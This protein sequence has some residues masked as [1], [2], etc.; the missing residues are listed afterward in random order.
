M[1]PVH[2]HLGTE[3]TVLCQRAIVHQGAIMWVNR[4]TQDVLDRI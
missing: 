3:I 4:L 1:H 2:L